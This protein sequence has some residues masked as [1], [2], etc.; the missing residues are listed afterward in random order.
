MTALG[1]QTAI[2][3]SPTVKKV[4]GFVVDIGRDFS[5]TP[6]GRYKRLGPFSGEE[7]RKEILVPRLRTAMERG[8]KLVVRI[9]RVRRSY[10]SSFLD[11]AFAGLV[12]DEGFS[13]QDVKNHLSILSD[14]PRFAKYRTL[15][16]QYLDSVR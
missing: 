1:Y 3:P 5:E 4:D 2:R 10:Q 7:F 6:G 8:E 15:A 13:Y 9:D 11:E 12:R 16:E 14:S